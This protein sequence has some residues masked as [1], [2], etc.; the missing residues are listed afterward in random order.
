VLVPGSTEMPLLILMWA[1]SLL[2]LIMALL[3]QRLNKERSL[4][5]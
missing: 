4:D 3:V 2:G 5:D 1:S